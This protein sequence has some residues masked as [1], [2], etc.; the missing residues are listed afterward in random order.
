[1]F[2]GEFEREWILLGGGCKGLRFVPPNA[3]ADI[4][5]GA[6][7]LLRRQGTGRGSEPG[8]GGEEAAGQHVGGQTS[9]AKH[10]CSPGKGIG[11][12]DSKSAAG[13]AAPGRLRACTLP[14]PA[15]LRRTP[16][17]CFQVPC[18]RGDVT[19]LEERVH[20]LKKLR[21]P[22][23]STAWEGDAHHQ[24]RPVGTRAQG[25]CGMMPLGDCF[26]NGQP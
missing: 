19:E 16:V 7:R 10:R 26:D 1:M 15:V 5:H 4:C 11:V 25:Y 8:E 23:S 12:S 24:S 13:H 22:S 6:W 2:D 9:G 18:R 14:Y 3:T 17:A 21:G 20:A